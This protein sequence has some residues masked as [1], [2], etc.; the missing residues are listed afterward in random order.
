MDPTQQSYLIVGAGMFGASTALH[1]RRSNPSATVTLLDR[2]PFPC[3]SA[4]AHDLNKII[5][6]D[7]DDIFYMKLALEAQELWRTDPIYKPYYHESGML[8]AEN[9]GMGQGSIENYK[10][11]RADFDAEML[12]PED[13]RTRFNGIFHDAEWTGVKGCFWNPRSGWGEA[14]L[15]MKN[16]IQTAIDEG[17]T[18]IEATVSIIS[19]DQSG[20]CTGVRTEDGREL[21]ADHTILCTGARTAKLLADSKPDKKELQ[22]DG[23]M[24]AAAAVMCTAVIPPEKRGKFKHVPVVF[25]GL[26]H[27]HG[28]SP[29]VS[30]C[31]DVVTYETGLSGESI[32]PTADGRL[33]FTYEVSFTNMVYHEKSKQTISVPPEPVSQST[34]SH[35]VPQGLKDDVLRVM[36]H[37][38][39]SE[40]EGF[41]IEHYRMCW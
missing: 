29:S 14:H 23:R 15:T 34:W 19:I 36:K 2:T 8:F 6:A 40:V 13:A 37:I 35:D 4:A 17:V 16:V 7:Y 26:D 22:M 1:L 39:G 30:R 11:L 20:I 9:I 3:P 24:V 28:S 25:N 38:Y 41:E 21:T 32:P 18:Y 31:K 27:T 12:R 33:K 5:R 10:T